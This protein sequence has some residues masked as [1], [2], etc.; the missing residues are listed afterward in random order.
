MSTTAYL[1][2]AVGGLAVLVLTRILV[3]SGPWRSNGAT[4]SERNRAEWYRRDWL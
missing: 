1:L 3:R 2:I 4:R